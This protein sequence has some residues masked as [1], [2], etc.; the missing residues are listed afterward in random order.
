MAVNE[1]QSL[2]IFDITQTYQRI[3]SNEDVGN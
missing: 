1:Q 2:M 3:L